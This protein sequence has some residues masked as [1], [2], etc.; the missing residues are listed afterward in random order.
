MVD[1]R[2]ALPDIQEKHERFLSSINKLNDGL[3]ERLLRIAELVAGRP[4][5]DLAEGTYLFVYLA[6]STKATSHAESTRS[7]IHAGRYG[8]AS[9]LMRGF[10]GDVIMLQYIAAYPDSCPEICEM[11][12]VRDQGWARGSRYRELSDR[13]KESELR[14]MVSE[15]GDH[16]WAGEVYGLYSEPAHPSIFGLKF[17]G[18]QIKGA[19]AE[20][21]MIWAPRFEQVASFRC[22]SGLTAL[23]VDVVD[24]FFVWDQRYGQRDWIEDAAAEWT[25][26]R[27][28]YFD[29]VQSVTDYLIE[30]H[31]RLYP[32]IADNT[33]R[34]SAP[35]ARDSS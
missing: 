15:A 14:R 2:R 30:S 27:E 4:E 23:L 13:F 33:P 17:Y 25:V 18:Q 9:M 26:V 6:L 24:T 5:S 3:L 31:K 21:L 16:P 35:D 8:D 12:K 34:A 20:F 10:M 11:S 19:E 32:P 7:L 22:A 29:Q 1:F 28:D